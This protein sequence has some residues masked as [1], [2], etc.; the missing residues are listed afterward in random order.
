MPLLER[1]LAQASLM[2]NSRAYWHL[3]EGRG[4]TVD[5]FRACLAHLEQVLLNYQRLSAARAERRVR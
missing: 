4:A 5:D 1:A 2:F 3:Y